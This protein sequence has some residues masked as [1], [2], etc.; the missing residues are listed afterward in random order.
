M[1]TWLVVAAAVCFGTTGTA[2]A[3]GAADASAVSLGA[4]RIVLGGAILAMLAIWRP[5]SKL[6]SH[7][8]VVRWPRRGSVA[9]VC[10]GALGVAAYQPAFFLGTGENGVAVGTLVALGSAPALTGLLEWLVLRRRP[11]GR[12]AVATAVAAAG[13]LVLSGVLSGLDGS[14]TALGLAGS[15]AA[16]ASYAVYTLS[17]KALLDRG[18]DPAS[19]MGATFGIA[20]LGLLPV[21]VVSDVTWLTEPA[22]LATALWLAVI[23]TAVAYTFFAQGLQS[24]PAARVATITL[25]EPVTAT[26]L[27]I[28]VLHENFSVATVIGVSL[29]L[30]GLAILTAG[31]RKLRAVA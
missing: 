26:I 16:G 31:R 3:L 6:S 1:S 4:A 21:L 15:I 22:G 25:L 8:R 18:W 23:T 24:L 2:Q 10:A 12:W 13:V 19:T 20:A 28:V 17:S 30:A 5:R 29:L 14:L 11:T 7:A 9:L 27:G